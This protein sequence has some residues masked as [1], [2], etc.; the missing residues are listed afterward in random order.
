MKSQENME[1]FVK[2]RKPQVKTSRQMDK[3]TLD[4]SFAAMDQTI[5]TKSTELKPSA[6]GIIIRSRV[7]KLAAAA[8]V[9]IVATGL[10]AVIVR[11]GPD[12]PPVPNPTK[13][14]SAISLTMA[15]RRGGIDALD[16]QCEKAIRILGS[17]TQRLTL[18]Q[19][20]KENNG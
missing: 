14:T 20:L 8:A 19:L 16:E 11:Q 2:D 6:H 3:R 4:D 17:R 18:G 5:R 15:Y 12:E 10:I 9:I 13:M 7:I 1:K